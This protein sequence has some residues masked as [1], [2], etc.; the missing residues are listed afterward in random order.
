MSRLLIAP[1]VEGHGE[2][3]AIGILLRRLGSEI[4]PQT[5]MV[6]LRP[7]RQPRSRLAKEPALSQA[8]EL[9]SRKLRQAAAA[10]DRLLVL[11]LV[12]G[13]G[14]QPC[15]FGP[16]LLAVAEQAVPHVEAAAVVAYPEYETWFVA[17]AGSLLADL[18]YADPSALPEDPEGHGLKKAWIEKHAAGRRYSETLDQPRFTARMDLRLCRERS[19]SFDKLWREIEKRLLAPL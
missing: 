9:A 3:E 4:A 8:A 2:V 1:I 10:D 17:A 11:V 12:D 7:L 18:P 6:V 5:E 19:P 14:G 13:S 15:V 16:K